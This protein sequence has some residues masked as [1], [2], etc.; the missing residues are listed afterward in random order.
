MVVGLTFALSR[1]PRR[2]ATTDSGRAGSSARLYG[3][4]SAAT[5]ET[6]RLVYNPDVRITTRRRA[7]SRATKCAGV[8]DSPGAESYSTARCREAARAESRTGHATN[9]PQPSKK[10]P[11]T[12]APRFVSQ[13]ET[14]G[15]AR[16]ARAFERPPSTQ[17]ENELGAVR[18]TFA[19]SRGAYFSP[20]PTA[21]ARCYTAARESS[22]RTR[23]PLRQQPFEQPSSVVR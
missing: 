1:T 19:L 23:L 18:I 15:C 4:S 5:S 8:P 12:P 7:L 10:Q 2:Q 21:P 6:E 3:P 17:K 14:A 22:P 11:A 16:L 20:A 9:S 13:F